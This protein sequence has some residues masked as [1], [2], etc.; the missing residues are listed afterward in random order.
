MHYTDRYGSPLNVGDRIVIALSKGRS[1][2]HMYDTKVVALIPLVPHRDRLGAPG[3]N[4]YETLMREDQGNKPYPGEYHV[5]K[6]TPPDKRFVIQYE[7]LNWKGEPRKQAIDRVMDIVKVPVE[8][9]RRE[10]GQL[11]ASA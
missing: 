4:D 1:S 7:K 6:D 8:V 9:V 3:R 2:A 11:V 5:H 10:E